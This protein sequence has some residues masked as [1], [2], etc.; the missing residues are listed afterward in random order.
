MEFDLHRR[1][2][3]SRERDW[4]IGNC[5]CAPLHRIIERKDTGSL[6]VYKPENDCVFGI[7]VCK[8]RNLALQGSDGI[9]NDNQN[10]ILG[11]GCLF[12]VASAA[13]SISEFNGE[14]VFI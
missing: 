2:A 13:E 10:H 6:A 4:G 1:A 3:D 9:L 11:R 14:S 7:S 12:T 5:T 8:K